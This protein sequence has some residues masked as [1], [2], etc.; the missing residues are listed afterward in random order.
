MFGTSE[1]TW[2]SLSTVNISIAET[3]SEYAFFDAQICIKPVT[4][5]L[6]GSWEGL[7]KDANDETVCSFRFTICSFRCHFAEIV[8]ENPKLS[9]K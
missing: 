9:A 6:I 8:E 1:I 5:H 2:H 7:S 3:L 4:N